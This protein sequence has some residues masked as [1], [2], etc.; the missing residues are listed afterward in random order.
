M[1]PQFTNIDS[2]IVEKIK[3]GNPNAT[4]NFPELEYSKKTV[5][6]RAISGADSGCIMTS[7]ANAKIFA[8]AGDVASNVLSTYGYGDG[9]GAIGV[10]WDG[11]VI[12]AIDYHSGRPSPIITSLSVKEGK[13]QISR[14]CDLSITCY[15]IEQ[16]ELIQQYY[17]EPGYTLLIE[18][19]FNTPEGVS[20][21][22]A[23]G[24]GKLSARAGSNNLDQ[25][26]L[27]E[28]R[29]ESYG[30]YDSFMG[31]IVGGSTS[32][33]DDKFI[34][35]VKLRGAPGMPTWMQS[36]HIIKKYDIDNAVDSKKSVSNSAIATKFALSDL[37]MTDSTI[38]GY[39]PERR[40]KYMFNNLPEQRRTHGVKRIK[41]GIE[42]SPKARKWDTF[43]CIN[44]DP[45]IN[46]IM[47]QFKTTTTTENQ[48]LGG[49]GPSGTGTVAGF[50]AAAFGQKGGDVSINTDTTEGEKSN[51]QTAGGYTIPKEKIFS[52]KEFIKF[53]RVVDI[54][55]QNEGLAAFKIGEKPVYITI[56]IENTV[57][58][59]FRG[60]Y[61]TDSDKLLITGEIPN[62]S[63]FFMSETEV[64][65]GVPPE[66]ISTT[67]NTRTLDN[68]FAQPFVLDGNIPGNKDSKGN[69]LYREE[70][71]HWGYLK[72]LYVNFNLF[73]KTLET[74]GLNMRQILEKLLN[75]MASA[76]NGFW[77]F[78]IVE[79][80]HEEKTGQKGSKGEEIVRKTTRYTIIDENWAGQ[81]NGEPVV[82]K[83]MGPESRFLDASL[84]FDIPGGMTSQ[85]V[86]KRLDYAVNPNAP[87]LKVGGM[88]NA[89]KDMFL[90][91]VNMGA[92]GAGTTKTEKAP[93]TVR[94]SYQS[95]I[96]GT[97]DSP[98]YET[99]YEDVTFVTQDLADRYQAT[100][101]KSGGV[102]ELTKKLTEAQSKFDAARKI[103]D[104]KIEREFNSPTHYDKEAEKVSDDAKDE[105]EKIKGELEKAQTALD[106]EWGDIQKT[107]EE[108]KQGNI[109]SNFDKITILP[110]PEIDNITDVD[111]SDAFFKPEIFNKNFKIYTCKDTAYFDVLKQNAFGGGHSQTGRYSHP[112]PIKYEFT[113]FGTSG[114]RRGDTFN[115]DGIPAKYKEHGL[116]QITQ[117]EQSISD[118]K[119][120]TKVLGEYRQQQ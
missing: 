42:K 40:F 25:D 11:K 24:D 60:I 85:I 64:T 13:D 119:W 33:D 4:G 18:Y 76:A 43:D 26:K 2:K 80:S 65:L 20:K 114:I 49:N 87:V 91:K 71:H 34:V 73:K 90:G 28:N 15:S 104:S 84:S 99:R 30:E 23:T 45:V 9:S 94:R 70:A 67:S 81:G 116:F 113:M 61:S 47:T 62:F 68:W 101:E 78:Q 97:K 3:K 8:A 74:D 27:H 31:F 56:D 52:D 95:Q 55:N 105:L 96:P 53:E 66:L 112:L 75:E 120:T 107:N 51:Y 88:F 72:N 12:R 102:E 37:N 38:A 14:H 106:K 5:W 22:L 77:N 48:P 54:L 86:A 46:R 117:V 83:H 109:S 1:W 19:G 100:L 118:M 110:N 57:I 58:G 50:N 41:D 21:L 98:K 10:D 89:K 108:T 44:M 103:A 16:M 17:M 92:G 93:L 115:I 111:L 69:T 6:I 63:K 29:I 79:K 7:N 82:F 35:N 39:I 59:A 32:M 36:Q